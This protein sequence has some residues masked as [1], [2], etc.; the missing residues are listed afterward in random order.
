MNVS[1]VPS[2]LNQL[3]KASWRFQQTFKTP[4]KKLHTFVASIVLTGAPQTACITVEQVVLEG[5]VRRV[6]GRKTSR[7]LGSFLK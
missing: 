4:L 7:P 3:R 6:E 1:I 2:A 5:S